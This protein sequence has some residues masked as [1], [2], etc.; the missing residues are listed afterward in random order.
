MGALLCE[1]CQDVLINKLGDWKVY[2]SVTI[3]FIKC[4]P[5]VSD[6]FVLGIEWF[7]GSPAVLPEAGV[8]L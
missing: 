5:Q 8:L 3:I 6:K 2:E 1:P 7:V 4:L